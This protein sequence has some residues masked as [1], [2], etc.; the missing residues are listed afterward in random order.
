[1]ERNEIKEANRKAMP[2]F[3]LLALVGAIVGG[4]VG[5]YSAK[6]DV[7][8]LAGSMKS[9]GAFFGNYVSSWIL[10]AIAV[11][12]PIVV[13]PVYQK[14]KRLL[15]AWDGEDESVCDIAEKKLNTV[16][17][18]NGIALISAFFLISATYSGGFAMI[19]KHLNMYVLAI[20][21]FLVILAEGIITQQK[22][23]DIIKIMYPEKT[24][25][26]YDL[27][28]QKKW[29]DSCD[30]AEKIMIGRCAFEA[31]KV[32]NSVCGALSVILAISALMFD[33]GFLPSF[34]V[35][36][37]WLVNQCAYCRAAAKCSKVL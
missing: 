3:L 37:I 29:V 8:R 31:F 14:T 35:C 2:R 24:A 13:I 10:L 32:T 19:E 16:L 21:A 4:I 26:V 22:V 30:E 11:I 12:T 34:V 1:M 15:L 5:F 17:L 33:I 7:D 36:L 28:F 18:I 9:A 27:K 20:V 25:S 23:V 6:Y